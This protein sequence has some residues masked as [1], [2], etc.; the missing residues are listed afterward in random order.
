MAGLFLFFS[1]RFFIKKAPERGYGRA[2]LLI[3]RIYKTVSLVLVLLAILFAI[4]KRG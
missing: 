2:M 4:L 1:C 3:W